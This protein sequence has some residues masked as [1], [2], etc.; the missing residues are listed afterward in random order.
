MLVQPW[1]GLSKK[2]S[3]QLL[4]SGLAILQVT[5]LGKVEEYCKSVLPLA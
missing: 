2:A 4:F 3:L 1:S 5:E